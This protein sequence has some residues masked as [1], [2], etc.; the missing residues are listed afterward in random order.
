[1]GQAVL[2]MCVSFR[3][4]LLSV[5]FSG[6]DSTTRTFYIGIREEMWD[7]APTGRNTVTGRVID[8]DQQ[9]SLFLQQGPHRIGRVYKKAVYKQYT[10]ETYSKEIAKPSWLG[11]LGPLLMAEVDDVIVVHLKNFASRPYSMH[12]HGVFYK[13]DSEGALYP[14]K[15]TGKNKTDDQVLPGGNYTYEWVVKP[16]YAPADGDKP[17]LTWVYHSHVH[18]SQDIASGLIGGLIT[19]K[20]G[21][22]FNPSN[23]TKPE[24]K[25]VDKD[26]F[27]MF[28]VVDENLSWY[29]EEN[30]Q[31][32][33]SD[34]TGVDRDSEEFQE[35][36]R[37]HA[38][39]GYV[40]GNLPGLE[41][42]HNHT[43][44]WH[45]L[46]MG[47]EVDVHA[48]NFHGHTLLDRGHRT[49]VLSLFPASLVTAEMFAGTTGKWML[50]CQVNDHIQAGMQA[51]YW[52][53]SCGKETGGDQGGP[54]SGTTRH[55]YIAAEEQLWNY[56]PTGINA[57]NNLSLSDSYFG[58]MRGHLG[59]VYRK[60]HYVAYTDDTFT[61]KK[62]AMDAEKHLGI[63]GPV[64]RAETG[65]LIHVTFLNKASRNYSILPHGIQ[66]EEGYEGSSYGTGE[67][68]HWVPP[69]Q[70][71][72]YRWR[73]MEG[74]SPSD[75]ACISFLYYSATDPVR[76]TNSGLV[77]PLL[78]CKSNTLDQSGAQKGVD[79]EFF[80]LFSLMDENLSWYLEDNIEMFGSNN[81]EPQDKDFQDSNIM[82]AVNGFLYGNLP[83]LDL[84]LGDRVSWHAFGLGS[85]MDIH[86]IHFE[87]N[88]VQ[89]EGLRRD[90]FN[91][92]PHTTVTVSM[93]PDSIGRFEI[94]CMTTDHYEAGMR[95][96]YTVQ[97]CT[98]PH[99]EPTTTP[100]VLHYFIAA[101]E[102]EWNYAPDRTWELE[103]HNATKE[104]SPGSIF[105][106]NGENR[107]GPKYKKVVFREYT[108][109]SFLER[110]IRSSTE[111]HLEIMGPIIKAEVG[112]QILIT[113]RNNA[114]RAY[115]MYGHGV[116]MSQ[117]PDAVEPGDVKEYRWNIPESSGPGPSDPNCISFAYHSS[118]DFVKDTVSGLI[119]PL[120]ICRKGTLSQSRCRKDVDREFALLFMVFNENL[121]WYLGDNIK[122]YLGKDPGTFSMT[123]EFEESNK[124]HAIN[125]KLYGNLNGLILMEGDRVDWYLLGMGSEV[126][127]HTVHFH[128]E[129]FTYKT[130]WTHRSDVFELFPGTFQTV[131]MVARNPGNWL[132]HCH[133]ADHILAGMET[134]FTIRSSAGE[135]QGENWIRF[136]FFISNMTV[137]EDD[138]DLKPMR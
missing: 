40:F 134:T 90:T 37:M 30:I 84:C 33:C 118:I 53:F 26:F 126:D 51:F 35:S 94:S 105:V 87:G 120:V 119:G 3:L 123:P 107:I 127:M 50:S 12:P 86:G 96:Q 58:T 56:G 61:T 13:K 48:A 25:D 4:V 23:Q 122:S 102:L 8:Q 63:L 39:N 73:V 68:G 11:Y 89:W 136:L 88:T 80:L 5:L 14:D 76:D 128:G 75:P 117:H 130:N 106:G 100:L 103:K 78:V 38:I 49:D 101:E 34:P 108:N 121:S 79:K 2:K 133:V 92:F 62:E 132:M 60:A 74:P 97:R 57:L 28:S 1:M 77:G 9:A 43:V 10:S 36:N 135:E 59:G 115:S 21:T 54:P 70:R 99:A 65:D 64:I 52:V 18:S 138:D 45:L 113:F 55:Y 19:C 47:N 110:K 114:S 16:Q 98:R 72:T 24:R 6:L 15:T 27:L 42:C 31:T 129:T 125:G 124:M 67:S 85:E 32:F 7:F 112:E 137:Q 109:S 116:K 69:G 17:C 104:T 111:E 93:A 44:A 83:G 91:L 41:I 46:G 71:F 81:S 82:H 20:K 131:S 95:H 22:L 66:Y 29:L